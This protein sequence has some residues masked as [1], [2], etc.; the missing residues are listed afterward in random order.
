MNTKKYL[1]KNIKDGEIAIKISEDK[2]ELLLSLIILIHQKPISVPISVVGDNK[3]QIPS[4]Q[5]EVALALA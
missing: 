1:L 3:S 2:I 5:T 4:M